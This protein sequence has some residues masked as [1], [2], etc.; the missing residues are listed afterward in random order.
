[1]PTRDETPFGAPCWIDLYTSDPD[2]SRSFYGDLFGWT[3]EDAGEEFGGY[4]T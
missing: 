1:M 2:A 4:I 3:S